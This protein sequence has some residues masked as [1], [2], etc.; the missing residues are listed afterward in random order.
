MLVSNTVRRIPVSASIPSTLSTGRMKSGSDTFKNTCLMSPRIPNYISNANFTLRRIHMED[1]T[2][3]CV[4]R[5]YVSLLEPLSN[6]PPSRK[7]QTFSS[8]LR[9]NR[10]ISLMV[11]CCGSSRQ[12]R[13]SVHSH[14]FLCLRTRSACSWLGWA[15]V[16]WR[17]L[18][19][20]LGQ[21]RGPCR[22]ILLVTLSLLLFF[23]CLFVRCCHC[24]F[25]FILNFSSKHNSGGN[26]RA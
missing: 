22:C 15:R 13:Q 1:K 25:F 17:V 24:F 2:E 12:G 11:C 19:A 7:L 16:T 3:G 4:S 10:K 23:S 6:D 26:E 18:G 5:P 21:A 14:C 20:R 8:S 9:G